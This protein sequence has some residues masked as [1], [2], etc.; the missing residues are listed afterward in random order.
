M[1]LFTQHGEFQLNFD[2]NRSQ[3]ENF[4]FNAANQQK[5]KIKKNNKIE[6]LLLLINLQIFVWQKRHTV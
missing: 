1:S 3:C 2:L 6:N 5:R 4:L